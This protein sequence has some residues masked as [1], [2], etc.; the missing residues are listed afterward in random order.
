[1]ALPVGTNSDQRDLHAWEIR[2]IRAKMAAEAFDEEPPRS[3][4]EIELDRALIAK[5]IDPNADWRAM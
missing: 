3:K 1:M 4:A 5:G 2:R